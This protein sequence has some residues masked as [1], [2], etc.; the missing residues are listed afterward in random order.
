MSV[1]HSCHMRMLNQTKICTAV[2]IQASRVP[3]PTP[4][5]KL[6]VGLGTR[7]DTSCMGGYTL[8]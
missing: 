8:F 4:D 1:V 2:V 5:E 7:L 6:G 3:S